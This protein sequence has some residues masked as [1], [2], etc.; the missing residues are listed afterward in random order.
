MAL[1]RIF[2]K[3][4][5]KIISTLLFVMLIGYM[6]ASEPKYVGYKP[7]QPINFSHKIHSNE[8]QIDCQFCHVGVEKGKHAVIPDTA[9]CIKCHQNVASDS[10]DIQ[11]LRQAYKEGTPIRWTKVYDLPDHVRFTHMPHVSIGLDCK[12]CHGDVAM[13]DKV[14]VTAP[15]NM[16]WCVGCHRQKTEELKLQELPPGSN[17]SVHLAECGICHY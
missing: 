7:D 14:E 16:G 9:T 2:K 15:F 8:L 17:V 3:H 5:G 6:F 10:V 4:R 12:E 13:M 1:K 11:Y